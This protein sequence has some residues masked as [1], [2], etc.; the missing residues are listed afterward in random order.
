MLGQ[1][2]RGICIATSSC[3][4]VGCPSLSSMPWGAS[5]RDDAERW[6]GDEDSGKTDSTRG[7]ENHVIRRKKPKTVARNGGT[8]G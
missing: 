7:R 5:K 4:R 3:G 2:M 8:G 6:I 1:G